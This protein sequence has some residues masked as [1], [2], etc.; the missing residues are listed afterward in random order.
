MF[1]LTPLRNFLIAAT[2]AT[3]ATYFH[4]KPKFDNLLDNIL[5]YY[6]HGPLE[7]N[8]PFSMTPTRDIFGAN[9]SIH[10]PQNTYPIKLDGENVTMLAKSRTG[11]FPVK[12]V[13]TEQDLN[14]DG[15]KNDYLFTD[16]RGKIFPFTSVQKSKDLKY[17][18][19]QSPKE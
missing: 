12:L 19:I 4:E 1:E 7:N 2:I 11:V 14:K 5:E 10:Y 16:S 3:A 15:K 9:Y 13:K 8:I 18:R 6:E 17:L